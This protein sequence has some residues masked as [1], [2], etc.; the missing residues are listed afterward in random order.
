MGNTL[1]RNAEKEVHVAEI[2]QHGDKLI[3][4]EK[5]PLPSAIDLIKRRMQ[6][7][8]E[9]V[10]LNETFNAFPYDG[11]Y[12]LEQVLVDMFG[13]APTKTKAGSFFTP[14]QPPAII[15]VEI[16]P[17]KIAGVPWGQFNLPT[18]DGVLECDTDRKD[19]MIRF[20]LTATVKRKDESTIKDLYRRV[21]EYLSENSIYR[22]Q[23]IKLRFRDDNGKPLAMPEPKFMDTAKIDPSALIYSKDVQRSIDTN[24]FTPIRRV[25][26]CIANGIP[27]K[28]GI[29]LGGVFGTGKTLAAVV[30]SKHA[31]DNGLTFIYVQRADE[32]DDAIHFAKLYREPAAVLFC[33]D[34]DRSLKG[35]RSVKIDDILNT[36]D[37]IDS[38]T[39]NL[40]TVLTSNNLEAINP[41]MLRPGRLDAIIEVTPPDAEACERLIRFYGGQ[42]IDADTDLT[43]AGARLAGTIPAIIA[44]VVKRA[45]LSQLSQQPE[46]TLVRKLTSEALADAAFTMKTQQELL[47]RAS[48]P[49]PGA[50]ELTQALER[51]IRRVHDEAGLKL[52]GEVN[53]PGLPGTAD[54][55]QTV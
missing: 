46:G 38:K 17:N 48:A 7:E 2:V 24:L 42:A 53:L 51:V 49:K 54:L 13:W 40:I 39:L 28:R 30:A 23:A 43:E 27:V 18:V 26:D 21:R 4:P 34:I 3:I 11:A 25:K 10:E 37:G 6:Y 5:M 12:A 41:A 55:R 8:Q 19:G 45:K 1:E 50:P 32:L 36:I 33:E 44:E 22:G 52:H 14:P 15:N 16:G 20:K 29:M 31:V 35:E 47:E 9:T